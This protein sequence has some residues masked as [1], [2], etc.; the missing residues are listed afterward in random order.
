MDSE[1]SLCDC[2]TWCSDGRP[3]ITEHHRDCPKHHLESEALALV[4]DLIRA[5]EGWAAD[6]DGVHPDAWKAYCN[7]LVFVGDFRRLTVVL[8][9]N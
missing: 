2:R 7:A 5:I 4:S 1:H 6:A 9:H 8:K 3:P